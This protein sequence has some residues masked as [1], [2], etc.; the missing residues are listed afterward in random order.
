MRKRIL[1]NH[2]GAQQSAATIFSTTR[3]AFT[4]V[5]GGVLALKRKTGSILSKALPGMLTIR[6][7]LICNETEYLKALPKYIMQS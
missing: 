5:F 6:Y 4:S 1:D 3:D 2:S 7:V